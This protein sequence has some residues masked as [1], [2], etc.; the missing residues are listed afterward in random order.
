MNLYCCNESHC[1]E[2][3]QKKK[4]LFDGLLVTKTQKSM[5]CLWRHWLY[6]VFYDYTVFIFFDFFFLFICLW[7]LTGTGSEFLCFEGM[8]GGDGGGGVGGWS[9]SVWPLWPPCQFSGTCLPHWYFSAW[10]QSTNTSCYNS[11]ASACLSYFAL[12]ADLEG[13][14]K[15]QL[16]HESEIFS[17]TKV[18]EHNA[19]HRDYILSIN[20]FTAA[21]VM[22]APARQSG[23][24]VM[25]K[26]KKTTWLVYFIL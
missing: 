21:E 23:A 16:Q 5:F 12:W 8:V 7:F 17:Y 25:K 22:W 13:E 3:D 20:T 4:R 9:S 2:G 6:I 10:E 19:E 26:T 14:D 24:E 18:Y 15:T 1:T 11:P